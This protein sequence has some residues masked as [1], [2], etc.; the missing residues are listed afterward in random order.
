MESLNLRYSNDK[1]DLEVS[2]LEERDTE[3]REFVPVVY[4]SFENYLKMFLW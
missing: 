3:S 1:Y 4:L 2:D